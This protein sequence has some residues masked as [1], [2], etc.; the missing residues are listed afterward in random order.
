MLPIRTQRPQNVRRQHHT[1]I[2]QFLQRLC[3]AFA[4]VKNQKVGDQV[5]VFDDLQLLVSYVLLNQVG[6]EVD[7]LGKFVKALTPVSRALNDTS[8]FFTVHVFQKEASANNSSEFPKCIVQLV[9]PAGG[10]E[11]TQDR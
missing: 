1:F 5:I 3:H 2:L 7:P 6:S 9:F 11:L 8:Q 10:A 4:I